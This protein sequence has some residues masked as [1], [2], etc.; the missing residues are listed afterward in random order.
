MT[1]TKLHPKNGPPLPLD[2]KLRVPH[3]IP[4]LLPLRPLRR[5]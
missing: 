3:Y 1:D 5:S 4:A 2:H